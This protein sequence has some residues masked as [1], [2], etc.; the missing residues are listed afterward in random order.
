MRAV[1]HVLAR[2]QWVCIR[3]NRRAATLALFFSLG[4]M[5]SS[6]VGVSRPLSV[7]QQGPDPFMVRLALVG[8]A[9]I[10]SYV[11]LSVRCV[12]ERLWSGVADA[13]TIIMALR[14]FHP[15]LAVSVVGWLG[16]VVLLLWLAAT[17]ISLGFVRS[18]FRGGSS[19]S[20]PRAITDQGGEG[21]G[22][23][24]CPACG[25]SLPRCAIR[26]A[27]SF[28]CST[29]SADLR[30]PRSYLWRSG[31]FGLAL[32]IAIACLLG[33][34]GGLFALALAAS[35]LPATIVVLAVSK[36]YC[37]PR[38]RLCETPRSGRAG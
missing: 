10:L 9:V 28:H 5:L 33:P 38:P 25:S 20:M 21:D 30:V 36:F 18:A 3:Q 34:T 12:Y 26:L 11:L 19:D 31:A 7:T 37:P 29:C 23:P 6:A 2:M 17:I 35:W 22:R 1:T 15:G 24:R 27:S 8:G 16:V 13:A 4:V 32:A 14:S